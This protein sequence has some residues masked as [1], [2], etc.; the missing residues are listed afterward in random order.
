MMFFV[1]FYN[2]TFQIALPFSDKDTHLLGKQVTLPAFPNV[3]H[4]GTQ[5]G[6]VQYHL[7]NLSSNDVVSNESSHMSVHF[8]TYTKIK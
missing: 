3:H 5:W 2:F 7:I 6:K 1:A 8:D 4:D